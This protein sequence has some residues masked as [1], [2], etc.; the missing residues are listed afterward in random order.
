MAKKAQAGVK[1]DFAQD[2]TSTE[3]DILFAAQAPT[4]P[5]HSIEV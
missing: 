3:K 1:N 2:L 5:S 4:S